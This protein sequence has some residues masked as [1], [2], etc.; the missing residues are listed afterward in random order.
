MLG[1]LATAVTVAALCAVPVRAQT[2]AELTRT[3]RLVADRVV[4]DAKF[5]FVDSATGRRYAAADSA[6]RVAGALEEGE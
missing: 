6:P 3:V 5:D 4:K 1:R 2:K